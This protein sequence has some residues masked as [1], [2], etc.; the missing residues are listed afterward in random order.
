M[1]NIN[2]ATN[3]K[4]SALKQF[5][6]PVRLLSIDTRRTDKFLRPFADE[7]ST[8]G[9]SVPTPAADAADQAYVDAVL[10]VLTHPACPGPLLENLLTIETASLPENAEIID[11]ALKRRIPGVGIPTDLLERAMELFFH[12]SEEL[13]R[14]RPATESGSPV[15]PH[16]DA[17]L[18]VLV[19][20]TENRILNTN[21]ATDGCSIIADLNT[22]NGKLNTQLITGHCSLIT[23]SDLDLNSENR[24]LNTL[25]NSTA[26]T[27][28]RFV[29]LPRHAADTLA[30]WILH[31]YA[32]ELR[33]VSTYIGI[34]SPEKRCGKTTPRRTHLPSRGGLQH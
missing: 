25:L 29:V 15:T 8:A 24:T 11:E 1:K 28:S 12:C 20:K 9:L 33:D 5:T 17:P 30:L 27:L 7:L 6:D 31:T 21:Q 23:N 32:Y 16:D 10:A 26:A 2:S 19:L 14:F 4:T 13:N 18:P 34:E 22:E 3:A